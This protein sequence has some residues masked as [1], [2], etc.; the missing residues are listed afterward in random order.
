MHKSKAADLQG[1]PKNRPVFGHSVHTA[2]A[3]NARRLFS[4]CPSLG[5]S[6][7]IAWSLSA[8]LTGKTYTTWWSLTER[9]MWFYSSSSLSIFSLIHSLY[10]HSLHTGRVGARRFWNCYLC[11]S[12]QFASIYKFKAVMNQGRYIFMQL[13]DF[14]PR[15]N[16]KWLVKSMKATNILRD[17]KGKKE[18]V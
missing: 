7:P 12:L 16:F 8:H 17:L 9:L 13:V 5:L 4:W 18:I 15:K 2:W 10:W 11:R 14:L 1:V 6:M 3:I